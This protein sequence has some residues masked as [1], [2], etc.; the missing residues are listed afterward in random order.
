[1][2]YSMGC[3]PSGNTLTTPTHTSSSTLT[4][5]PTHDF[6]ERVDFA[7][8]LSFPSQDFFTLRKPRLCGHPV[9]KDQTGLV[10]RFF[11]PV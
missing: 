9:M 1:M 3:K 10:N 5:A 8:G 11:N 2:P 4:I 6:P 7:S